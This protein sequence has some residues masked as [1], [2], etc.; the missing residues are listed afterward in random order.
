MRRAHSV[1]VLFLGFAALFATLP[2]SGVQAQLGERCFPETG[3][4]IAGRIREFW[5]RNGGLAVFGLPTSP[6]QE[7]RIEGK[8]IQLQWFERNRLELHP[9]NPRPYDVLLGRLGADRLAQ[10][11]VDW[12]QFPRSEPKRGCRYFPETGHNVCGAFLAAWRASGLELDGRRGKSE[13][14]NLAL[15]GLPLSDERIEVIAGNSYTVQWF[16]RAR[17]EFH[18]ENRPPYNVL[19]GLLGNEV[20]SPLRDVFAQAGA[21]EAFAFV[22]PPGNLDAQLTG[23]AFCRRS[24]R[25]GLRLIYNFTGAGNGGWG[26]AWN[27]APGGTFDARQFDT[28]AF[29]VRGT[30]PRGFQV[31]LKD[32]TGREVKI[33]SRDYVAASPDEWRK[34]TIPL[35]KFADASGAVNPSSV[36]NVNFGFNASHGSGNVCIA[37]IAF[38]APLA[39]I[40]SQISGGQPFEYANPPGVFSIQF[41]EDPACCR[42]GQYGLRIRYGFTGDGFGGWGVHWS[43]APGSV[44]DASRYRALVFWIKGTA[45]GGFQIGLKD[46]SEREGKLEAIELVRVRDNDWQKVTVPLSRFAAGGPVN[47]AVVRNINFGFNASHG[48][49]EVCIDDLGFE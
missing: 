25:H 16:E 6:Q 15:F 31:G 11:D 27:G 37:D 38:E 30:A 39:E 42:S 1:L 40:F 41:V 23:D 46:A 14:E 28:L 18:P 26:V 48:S 2:L 24:A 20:R 13:V 44:F 49:G 36:Q 45:P 33:E 19:F 10:M 9:E 3:F 4:C 34:V 17:F 8:T 32:A 47:V 43:N 22:N 7:E 21:A 12:R 35:G 5:E 29:W